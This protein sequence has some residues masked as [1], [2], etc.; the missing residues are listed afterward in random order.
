MTRDDK[1]LS[2]MR[3]ALS[4]NS[5]KLSLKSNYLKND[6]ETKNNKFY[7]MFIENF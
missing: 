2:H 1:F 4:K 6:Y 3:Y 7:F 5:F